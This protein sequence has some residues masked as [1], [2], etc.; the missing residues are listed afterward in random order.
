MIKLGIVSQ[1]IQGGWGGVKGL[2]R[3]ILQIIFI[4]LQGTRGH[5]RFS[6]APSV[7]L[8]PRWLITP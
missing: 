3:A 6:P 2:F 7:G 5:S 8:P 4:Y 1:G